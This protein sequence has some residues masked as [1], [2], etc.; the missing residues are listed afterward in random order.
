MTPPF[1][2][3]PSFAAVAPC[4]RST[5]LSSSSIFRF[6]GSL[7]TFLGFYILIVVIEL[8]DQMLN[9]KAVRPIRTSLLNN[10]FVRFV[11]SSEII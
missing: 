6:S 4:F 1:P 8:C 5:F 11:N 3:P 10:I 9:Y 2:A 7:L